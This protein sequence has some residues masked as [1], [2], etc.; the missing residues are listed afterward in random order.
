VVNLSLSSR[1]EA[2]GAIPELA[3]GPTARPAGPRQ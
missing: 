3:D 1:S 2:R